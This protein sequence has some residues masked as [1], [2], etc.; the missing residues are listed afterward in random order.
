[1]V[2]LSLPD[3]NPLLETKTA[4]PLLFFAPPPEQHLKNTK[5]GPAQT[6][7]KQVQQVRLLT[8]PTFSQTFNRIPNLGPLKF[9]SCNM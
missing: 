9:Q 8:K 7:V 6:S 3:S 2:L 1:M 4:A 5:N